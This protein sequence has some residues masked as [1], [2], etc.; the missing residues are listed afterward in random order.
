M[1]EPSPEA[2]AAVDAEVARRVKKIKEDSVEELA[3]EIA[4][5]LVD[6]G[7]RK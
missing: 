1:D 2:Y 7:W 6:S 4:R 5:V 3:R